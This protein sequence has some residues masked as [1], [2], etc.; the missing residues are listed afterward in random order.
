ANNSRLAGTWYSSSETIDINI[1]DNQTHSVAI[2][3]LD[4]DPANRTQW[5]EVHDAGNNALLDF[6]ALSA[7]QGGVYLIWNISG[8]VTITF[9][10]NTEP[11]NAV[12]SGIFFDSQLSTPAA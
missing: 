11:N 5:I 6:R 1:T 10:V 2:Y 3:C 8:H 12:I 9:N 7:F 4:Y